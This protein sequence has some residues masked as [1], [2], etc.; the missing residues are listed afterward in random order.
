MILKKS[1]KNNFKLILNGFVLLLSFFFAFFR[2]TKNQ[3]NLYFDEIT[4]TLG[5]ELIN[6]NYIE[7][8]SFRS[9][10]QV[11][12]R[13]DFW[14]SKFF[15]YIR[16]MGDLELMVFINRVPAALAWSL[17][18]IIFYFILK[19]IYTNYYERLFGTLIY[20]TSGLYLY[21]SHFLSLIAF[22]QLY[23]ISFFYFSFKFYKKPKILYF[24]LSIVFAI[25]STYTHAISSILNLT[26]I[27]IFFALNFSTNSIFL[28]N[29]KVVN[30]LSGKKIII[31]VLITILIFLSLYTPNFIK[32]ID[33]EKIK[34]TYSIFS[35]LSFD[36]IRFL[37]KEVLLRIFNY[38]TPLFIVIP[39]KITNSVFTDSYF[40]YPNAVNH[41]YNLWITEA[42][43]PFG[44][45]SFFAYYGIFRSFVEFKRKSSSSYNFLLSIFISYLLLAIVPNYG[46]P[47][48]AKISPLFIWIPIAIIF[49]IKN[50]IIRINTINKVKIKLVKIFITLL[51]I[52]SSFIN[53]IYI[54]SSTYQKRESDKFD[55]GYK[56][57]S[58]QIVNSKFLD[59][60]PLILLK[61]DKWSREKYLEYYLG[62]S[63]LNKTVKLSPN[64]TI[65]KNTID[66]NRNYILLTKYP[67]DLVDIKN[68]NLLIQTIKEYKTS[69]L[70]NDI[71]YLIVFG[72]YESKITNKLYPVPLNYVDIDNRIK[73]G[74]GFNLIPNQRIS[75]YED[76]TNGKSLD[77]QEI[78]T[79]NAYSDS[80]IVEPINYDYLKY[81]QDSTFSYKSIKSGDLWLNIYNYGY[82]IIINNI[83][84]CE[85]NVQLKFDSRFVELDNYKDISKKITITNCENNDFVLDNGIKQFNLSEINSLPIKITINPKN[86]L[87]LVS[88]NYKTTQFDISNELISKL[89]YIR[90]K[91]INNTENIN[92]IKT[93]NNILDNFDYKDF[94]LDDC[95]PY[96]SK[97]PIYKSYANIESIELISKN[98]GLCAK[99]LVS[100]FE[101][102]EYFFKYSYKNESGSKPGVCLRN[103]AK[104]TCYPNTT[105]EEKKSN[106]T[107]VFIF[108]EIDASS[109]ELIF[110]NLSSGNLLD[111]ESKNIIFKLEFRK[112]TN[113]F[114]NSFVVADPKLDLNNLKQIEA[115][116]SVEI[117]NNIL[118]FDTKKYQLKQYL[119]VS[120]IVYDENWV[121]ACGENIVKKPIMINNYLNGWIL[122]FDECEIKNDKINY[123]LKYKTKI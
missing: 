48:I 24:Y 6:K 10:V 40:I 30:N 25:L 109:T 85:Y 97:K 86:R 5:Q 33:N 76:F 8:S 113:G 41:R 54:N 96:T 3:T 18:A 104:D 39:G 92:N 56:E 57:A 12:I 68:N 15:S 62:P 110:S 20:I 108:T 2:L 45:I 35:Y 61:D 64:E 67:E 16:Y 36:Y 7:A 49:G 84:N 103:I 52:I 50:L 117:N 46:N 13:L 14:Q 31:L 115:L 4:S 38:T 94:K 102:G 23:T 73:R 27:I 9:L 122:S 63:I 83:V 28:R 58:Q 34:Q 72:K 53:I 79:N 43:S 95:T 75:F 59:Y 90:L 22:Y 80:N 74:E 29:F 55:Y 107:D 121:L 19:E 69:N 111:V 81:N 47:S 106:Y 100:N 98:S 114:R 42:I 89:K 112:F 32:P 17:S 26:F 99:Y 105:F 11:I 44:F 78:Y 88:R 77:F 70:S 101:K 118:H 65:D 120:N 60:D 21:Y 93:N 82:D 51:C 123:Q 66:K 91:F 1:I 37:P 87:T 119:Y 71:L 116:D